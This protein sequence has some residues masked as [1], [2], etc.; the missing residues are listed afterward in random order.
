[1]RNKLN[2]TTNEY[3]EFIST[4]GFFMSYM[5]TYLNN[6]YFKNGIKFP[7]NPEEIYTSI[8]FNKG[9]MHVL[10]DLLEDADKFFKAELWNENQKKNAQLLRGRRI[11][12]KT[13]S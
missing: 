10:L 4:F 7:Y 6:V 13:I 12:N 1:M 3:K 5:R 8:V 2:I 11:S 9:Q